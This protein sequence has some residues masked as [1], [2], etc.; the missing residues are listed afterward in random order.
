MRF[1]AARA[2]HSPHAYAREHASTHVCASWPN[3]FIC[4]PTCD[5][6]HT[7]THTYARVCVCVCVDG[8]ACYAHAS[9]V[10]LCTCVKSSARCVR[11]IHVLYAKL[12]RAIASRAT[13]AP[14]SERKIPR[15][16]NTVPFNRSVLIVRSR[17][18][19]RRVFRELFVRTTKIYQK[20]I[21]RVS[22]TSDAVS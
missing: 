19:G 13:V 11:R 8:R 1:H 21:S 15:W 6:V 20:D 5:R 12:E 10:S 4:L 14:R 7:Y 3:L 16:N 2:A 18:H 17:F 9:C 22:S